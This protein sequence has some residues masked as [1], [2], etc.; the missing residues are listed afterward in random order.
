MDAN[1]HSF[2]FKC[3]RLEKLASAQRGEGHGG[4]I[5]LN[6]ANL[7]IVALDF[8]IVSAVSMS[9][10]VNRNMLAAKTWQGVMQPL[11]LLLSISLQPIVRS[12]AELTCE[13]YEPCILAMHVVFKMI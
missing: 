3:L 5:F 8:V 7:L 11:Q 2:D 1:D 12:L 9:L 10:I 13:C 6:P 4:T